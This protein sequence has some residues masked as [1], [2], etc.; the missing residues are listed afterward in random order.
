MT[1]AQLHADAVAV[2][3]AYD[4]HDPLQQALRARYLDFLAEHPDALSRACASGHLTASTLVIDPSHGRVLLTHH[5]KAGRWLQFGGHC[6]DSDV[7][8]HGAALREA[9]EESGLPPGE[10]ELLPDPIDLDEHALGESFTCAP[11]HLDVRFVALARADSP[12]LAGAE[13]HDVRWLDVDDPA[14][15]DSSLVRL[16]ARATQLL[17][18]HQH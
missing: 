14:I 9:V 11:S 10:L 15:T 17:T 5:A 12:P 2:V 7:T 18:P 3:G 8:L 1:F 6:E 4:S 13:S 16:I